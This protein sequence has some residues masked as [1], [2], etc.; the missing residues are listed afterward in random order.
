MEKKIWTPSEM[1]K[2][3]GKKSAS[4]GSGVSLVPDTPKKKKEKAPS[5]VKPEET[6]PVK[7][8]KLEP[9]EPK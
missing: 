7:E 8:N 5:E 6:K 1:G 3:G 2:K 4:G 9:V